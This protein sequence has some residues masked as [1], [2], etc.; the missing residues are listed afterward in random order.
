ME[1]RVMGIS[2]VVGRL[3]LDQ[4][5]EVRTLHPQPYSIDSPV[6]APC[7]NTRFF[8]DLERPNVNWTLL[9]RQK[10][11]MTPAG[12][13]RNLFFPTGDPV[14]RLGPVPSRL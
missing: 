8:A 12:T 3:T 2:P 1:R 4:E 9:P 14:S 6:L 5:A 10:A 13:Y 11:S 7:T